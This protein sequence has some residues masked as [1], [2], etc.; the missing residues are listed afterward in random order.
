VQHEQHQNCPGGRVANTVQSL[1]P[2]VDTRGDGGYVVA[3][4]SHATA[5][6]YSVTDATEAQPL[7]DWL[8]AALTKRGIYHPDRSVTDELPDRAVTDEPDES[9][10]SE[11]LEAIA[12]VRS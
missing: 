1:A 3:P 4:P 2:G 12:C 8:L 6:A 11:E 5:G 10:E 9:D 7:P